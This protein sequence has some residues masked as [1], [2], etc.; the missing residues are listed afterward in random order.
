MFRDGKYLFSVEEK[1]GEEKCGKYLVDGGEE[2]GDGKG[3]KFS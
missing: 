2:K 1:K 3:G